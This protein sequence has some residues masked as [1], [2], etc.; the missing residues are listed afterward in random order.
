MM[1]PNDVAQHRFNTVRFNGY[2]TGDVDEFLDVLTEDYTALYKENAVLKS[3][4]KV[5]VEKIAEYR[6]TEDDI[7]LTLVAARKTADRLVEEANA[8]KQEL[9]AQAEGEVAEHRKV[10]REEIA[11][12]EAQLAA[13]RQSTLDFAAGMRALMAQQQGFIDRELD[14]LERLN[15]IKAEP[16]TAEESAPAAEP[17]KELDALDAL[18]DKD[19]M[20]QMAAAEAAAVASPESVYEQFSS[21]DLGMLVDEPT[22]VVD[23]NAA[24][25]QDYRV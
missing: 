25:D 14:F 3:K 12:T 13:A 11:N 22:R 2:N 9:M 21:D 24:A 23:M 8:H 7:R 20:E 1:T 18:G 15:E 10:L 17:A 4:I 19:L 16:E 6:A 5:L